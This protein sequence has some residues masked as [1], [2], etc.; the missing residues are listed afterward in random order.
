M[1]YIFR[2]GNVSS[3]W[4]LGFILIV[5]GQEYQFNKEDV[6]YDL[7]RIGTKF[8]DRNEAYRVDDPLDIDVSFEALMAKLEGLIRDCFNV[9]AK[10]LYNMEFRGFPR[11]QGQERSVLKC[12]IHPFG[13]K[14]A[15]RHKELDLWVQNALNVF[16]VPTQK[17]EPHALAL[18]SSH[19]VTSV[20]K[21]FESFVK[22]QEYYVCEV[23][24]DFL[25]GAGTLISGDGLILTCAHVLMGSEIKVR[26]N[27]GDLKGTYS[28]EIVFIDEI[29]DAALIK[30]INLRSDRWATVQLDKAAT[31]GEEIVAIGNPILL[32]A[33][34]SV[35]GVS[36][37]GVS[38]GIVSNPA[39]KSFGSTR[40]IGDIT[41]A[42][43]SSGGP[44]FSRKTGELIGVVTAV[45]SAGISYAKEVASSGYFCLA[46]P[47]N[48]LSQWLGIK[49]EN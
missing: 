14:V 42:S 23:L 20:I 39:V 13:P 4:K 31:K 49:Y 17:K 2:Q 18:K 3:G 5:S 15:Q 16:E 45:G 22:K 40:M 21:D 8:N 32:D 46:V 19:S 41:I 30:A 35:R 38:V 1:P 24:G 7:V 37:G 29:N 28:C 6:S 26:F 9:F 12:L 11:V 34:K 43:G 44:I 48:K 33:G 10:T 27:A 47:S 25:Q 36:V